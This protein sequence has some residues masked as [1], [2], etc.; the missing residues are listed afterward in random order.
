MKLESSRECWEVFPKSDLPSD[1]TLFNTA[2]IIFYRNRKKPSW[3]IENFPREKVK[4][5]GEKRIPFP[6]ISPLCACM[7]LKNQGTRVSQPTTDTCWLTA[8]PVR[9]T[10]LYR[11]N[12]IHRKRRRRLPSIRDA[13]QRVMLRTSLWTH[14]RLHTTARDRLVFT[15]SRR[16]PGGGEMGGNYFRYACTRTLCA[17]WHSNNPSRA[18]SEIIVRGG[19]CEKERVSLQYVF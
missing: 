3:I 10:A 14:F 9:R 11:Q 1:I 19:P 12:Q 5:N 17:T 18:N 16:A 15:K 6:V 4:I 13:F 8:R 2:F 7:I